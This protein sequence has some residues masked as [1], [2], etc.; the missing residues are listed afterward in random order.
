MSPVPFLTERARSF[1]QR[2][3]LNLLREL[4]PEGALKS[5]N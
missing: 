2:D 3:F 1:A 5:A 4:L